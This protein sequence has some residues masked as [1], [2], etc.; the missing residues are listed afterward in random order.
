MIPAYHEL[1][2][3][4]FALSVECW[5]E[6]KLIGGIYGVYV[7]NHF[8][9]ESMF[10]LETDV[11]KLCL[12]KLIKML[13]NKGLEWMDIQMVTPVT[14]QFGGKYVSRQ[15]FNRMLAKAAKKPA[16]LGG[17]FDPADWGWPQSS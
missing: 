4:G 8:S 3:R 7:N 12:L 17:G 11:S 14:Q 2:K 15:Q 1:F 9:A 5:K 13:Q 16:N 10:G 6:R